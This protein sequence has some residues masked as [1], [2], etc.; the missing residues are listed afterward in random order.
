MAKKTKKSH[1]RGKVAEDARRHRQAGSSYGYLNLPKGVRVFNPKPESRVK[2]DFLPY[3]VEDERHPD[4]NDEKKIAQPG[5][6][7]YKRLIRIHRGLGTDNREVVICPTSVGKKCPI[8]EYRAKLLREGADKDETDALKFSERYLY[9]VVPLDSKDHD[10]DIH[11][12]DISRY[13]FQK[14]LEQELNEDEDYEIFPD[15]DEGL[16]LKIRFESRTIG[17][18]QPFAE[19]SRID[20]Y[21]RDHVYTEDVLNDVPCLDTIFDVKSYKELQSMFFELEDET[22]EEEEEI[23]APTTRRRKYAKKEELEEREEEAEYEAEEA[24]PKKAVSRRT[25]KKSV[26]KTEDKCPYGHRFG[27]DTDEYDDCA[28][29]DLW[30]PCMDKKEELE[31]KEE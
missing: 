6:L 22:I 24:P 31:A 26:T 30:D 2:L 7:W 16:T 9:V 5:D 8:C 12:F 17:N 3:V 25:T 19:A 18:S 28:V 11:I 14:L 27:I 23:E 4:R 15:P 13:L 20:F 29:C 21:E 10:A 1:F